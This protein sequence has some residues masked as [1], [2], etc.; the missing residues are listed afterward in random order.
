MLQDLLSRGK[1]FQICILQ[2]TFILRPQPWHQAGN[3]HQYS[4]QL[5]GQVSEK[6]SIGARGREIDDVQQRQHF[7]S[8]ESFWG[9]PGNGAP[10]D[11]VQKENLMKMLHYNDSEVKNVRKLLA[12]IGYIKNFN[13]Y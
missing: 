5:S 9:R 3:K 11:S 1:L 7:E 6:L 13:F 8:W 12:L 4:D 2:I 10:R